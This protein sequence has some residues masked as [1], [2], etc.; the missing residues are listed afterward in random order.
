MGASVFT[1]RLLVIFSSNLLE[2]QIELAGL[3]FKQL[4]PQV[5][6]GFPLPLVY[7]MFDLVP[8]ADR[9]DEGKPIA[10]RLRIFRG[11]D[12]DDFTVS[13][14]VPQRDNPAVDLCADAVMT[15]LGMDRV[16]KI[17]RSGIPRKRDDLPLGGEAIHLVRV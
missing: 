16:C 17:H 1:R 11:K 4:L 13:K 3:F 2:R 7:P 9:L 15:D 8:G 14:L 12:F 5:R 10:V 6:G